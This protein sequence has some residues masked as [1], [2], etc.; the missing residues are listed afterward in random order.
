[1]R[2]GLAPAASMF[3]TTRPHCRALATK[4]GQWIDRELGFDT[5]LVH[6][7]VTPDAMSGAILTPIYQSTTYVQDSVDEYLAKGF[8]YSRTSNPTVNTLEKKIA[9][10]ESGAGASCFGTGMAATIAVVSA[11]MKAG[12]HCVITNCSYGGTNRACRTMFTD[13]GMT[14][15][16]ID[17]TDVANIESLPPTP[18]SPS[19][20]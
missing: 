10:L 9:E 16:F 4:S 18:P 5:K 7:A 19:P 13:M 20:T 12:D 6:A 2:R 8:S 17:F 11:T 3:R 15:D 14:F 1:M